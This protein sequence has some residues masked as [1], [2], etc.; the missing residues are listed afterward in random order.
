[1]N[2]TSLS[3]LDR[4]KE[5]GPDAVEWHRLKDV[6]LPLIRSWLARIP[7]LRDDADDLAQD[8]FIVLLRGLPAFERRRHGS[9]RAWL[10]QVATNRAKAFRKAGRKRGRSEGDGETE[11]DL[12]QLEDPNSNLARQWDRDYDL[13]LLG[14]LL[15]AV[16]PDFEPNTW[17]AFTRF[18][19][20]GLTAAATAQELGISESAVVQAKFRVLKRLREEAG[21][22]MS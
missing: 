9:F 14:K 18:A 13:H 20:D 22:L 7:G 4:L 8:V 2:T 16:R 11:R 3:L 6:Y 10:R 21:D 17:Q 1:M 5:A 12:D 19:L 15:A